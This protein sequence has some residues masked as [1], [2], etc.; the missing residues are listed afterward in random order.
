[1]IRQNI[2]KN[3][4]KKMQVTANRNVSTMVAKMRSLLFENKDKQMKALLFERALSDIFK[5]HF[6]APLDAFVI[7][8]YQGKDKKLWLARR[9]VNKLNDKVGYGLRLWQGHM[10]DQRRMDKNLKTLKFMNELNEVY[11]ANCL[12][13]MLHDT[14][15]SIRKSAALGKLCSAQNEKL[16]GLLKKWLDWSKLKSVQ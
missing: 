12:Q 9:F 3:Y 6:R 1:M 14:K 2:L 8:Q 15:G 16:S 10:R 13:N 5:N 7:D 4:F 11:L